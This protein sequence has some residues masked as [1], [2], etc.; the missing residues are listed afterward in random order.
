MVGLCIGIFVGLMIEERFI[1]YRAPRRI[2]SKIV[3]TA[4]LGLAVVGIAVAGLRALYGNPGLVVGG[5][6]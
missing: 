3:V 2:S 4:L 6:V 5:F 1:H